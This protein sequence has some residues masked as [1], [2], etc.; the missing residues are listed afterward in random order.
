MVITLFVLFLYWRYPRRMKTNLQKNNNNNTTNNKSQLVFS[1][2]PVR[3]LTSKQPMA[4]LSWISLLHGISNY[5][6]IIIC[7]LVKLILYSFNGSLLNSAHFATRGKTRALNGCL[8][9]VAFHKTRFDKLITCFWSDYQG[10]NTCVFLLS[11]F[12]SHCLFNGLCFQ[13]YWHYVTN[14]LTGFNC[15]NSPP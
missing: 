7:V 12:L 6:F 1:S 9:D 10:F 15:N 3:R 2:L 13:H 8:K 5:I 11:R 4:S 14:R